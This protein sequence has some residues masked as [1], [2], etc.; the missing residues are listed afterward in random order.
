[1]RNQL[2]TVRFQV[3]VQGHAFD[4][5]VNGQPY[6]HRTLFLTNVAKQI[7]RHVPS[8]ILALN[9]DSSKKSLPCHSRHFLGSVFIQHCAVE[10]APL[11]GQ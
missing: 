11:F 3:L 5:L 2:G 6:M 8:I 1:M 4:A 9:G 10:I 7:E